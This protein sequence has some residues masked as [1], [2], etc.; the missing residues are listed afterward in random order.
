MKTLASW[1]FYKNDSDKFDSLPEGSVFDQTVENI[2]GEKE[3][4]SKY[5]ENKNIFI[6]VNV[7]SACGLTDESY[8]DLQSLYDS[9]GSKGL[10]ILAFPCNQFKNQESGTNEEICSFTKSRYK[11]SFPLFSKIDVNG[12]NTH[13]VFQLLKANTKELSGKDGLKNVPWNFA[14]FLVD[15]EGQVVSYIGPNDSAL[16]FEEKIKNYL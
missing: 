5:T 9:Y 1:L 16:G 10:E 12:E 11:V 13:P 15:R 3:T 8:K 14:K 4:L 6:F 7:A 2:N